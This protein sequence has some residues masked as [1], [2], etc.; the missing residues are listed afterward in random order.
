MTLAEFGVGGGRLPNSSLPKELRDDETDAADTDERRSGCVGGGDESENGCF[1]V[2]T[3]ALATSSI[4]RFETASEMSSSLTRLRPGS[5][6][7]F[8]VLMAC[9]SVE[10]ESAELSDA[11]LVA[12]E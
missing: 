3:S 6:S 4:E 11:E 5:Q 9:A 7:E 2:L 12:L 1:P 10:E 8:F